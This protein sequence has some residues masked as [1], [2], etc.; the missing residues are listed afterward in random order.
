MERDTKDA[1]LPK[2]FHPAVWSHDQNP[3]SLANRRPRNYVE[4]ETAESSP[5][6][7][8]AAAG[9]R[10]K[11]INSFHHQPACL[12]CPKW[13]LCMVIPR[14]YRGYNMMQHTCDMTPCLKSQ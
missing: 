2:S 12:H 8:A 11:N 14:R 9:A 7:A 10:G 5:T 13:E 3:L 1:W 6:F 4:S